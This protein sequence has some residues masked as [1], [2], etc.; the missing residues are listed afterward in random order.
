MAKVFME[1]GGMMVYAE[2]SEAFAGQRANDF[3]DRVMMDRIVKP[4]FLE[5]VFGDDP[6]AEPEPVCEGVERDVVAIYDNAG[7]PSIMH[8]F[9]RITNKELFGGS[10][11][12]HPAFI[13]GGEVYDE[14]YISVYENVMINGKPYSLPMMEPVCNIAMEDFA[15]ACFSKGEGWHC[16]TA[17]EWGLLANTSLKLGTLPHGN[18]R[19]GCWHGDESEKGALIPGTGKTL[20]GSGPATWAHNH[21]TTGVHDLCGNLLE[22]CRGMRIINGA[23]QAAQDNDAALPET[24]LS[25]SG[26]GWK[27]IIDDAGNPL[28]VRV[29][30]EKITISTD[31]EK[32]GGW[33]GTRWGD[34][35]TLCQ[36]E[37]L[38]TLAWYAGEPDAWCFV[39]ATE[40]ECILLRGGYWRSGAG[41]GVFCGYL[42]YE[43]AVS[44]AGIG[45][46]SAYFKKHCARVPE[47]LNGERE[48]AGEG[49]EK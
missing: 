38:K 4:D 46:R 3:M 45:G 16:L 25:I 32:T 22:H 5:K 37:Q 23:L 42:N 10:D 29:S 36:S 31:P 18:T 14:I 35:E 2:G 24:D 12:V 15:A 40:G 27:P 20:T 44:G 19:G 7:I 33:G 34:V 41:A 26:S 39:D 48:R 17:A 8:R 47:T 30:S 9:R 13:I 21:K 43:R 28:F 6:Q 49:A 11:I 1:N